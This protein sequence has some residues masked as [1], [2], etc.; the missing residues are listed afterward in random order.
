MK[1][2]T[3][4]RLI[5]GTGAPP[6][7]NVNVLIDEGRIAAVGGDVPESAERLDG[8]G[9]TV[10]P[11]LIDAHVHISG[12]P[13]PGSAQYGAG[14]TSAALLALRTAR[15]ARLTLESGFTTIRDVGTNN[16][17]IFALRQAAAEGAIISP[18]IIASG[19]VITSTGGHGTEYG[20]LMYIEADTAEEIRRTVRAQVKAGADFIKM[21]TT[22]TAAPTGRRYYTVEQMK[23]GVDEAHAT[24]HRV[25]AHANASDEG[26]RRAV[27]A[28]VDTIEHGFPASDETLRLMLERGTILIPTLAVVQQLLNVDE[29]DSPFTP[30]AHK[31]LHQIYEQSLDVVRRAHKLGVKIALGTD[32]GSTNTWHGDSALELML[33]VECGM[34]PLEA[35]VAGTRNAA[36]ACGKAEQFGTLEAGKQADLIAVKGDPLADISMLRGHVDWVMQGGKIAFSRLRNIALGW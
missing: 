34:S 31:R 36:E 16:R 22:D 14:S 19:Q 29:K 11:G 10:L 15:F 7:E 30:A 17:L 3:N 9:Y 27:L 8:T 2:I 26:V 28:G 32:A 13:A 23:A 5:D 21:I 35:I 1:A 20:A 33:M 25:A 12:D 6:R 4:V 24:G 18:R